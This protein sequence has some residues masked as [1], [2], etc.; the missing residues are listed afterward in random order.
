MFITSIH[1]FL[2][3]TSFSV[4]FSPPPSPRFSTSRLLGSPVVM[5]A[6]P[7]TIIFFS[8]II[9]MLLSAQASG[10]DSGKP[11]VTKLMVEACKN[12]SINNPYNDPVTQEFCLSTLQSDNHIGEILTLPSDQFRQ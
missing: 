6:M 8:T 3:Y 2:Q 5:V 4:Y 10:S 12:A 9:F 7:R 11:K 1:P